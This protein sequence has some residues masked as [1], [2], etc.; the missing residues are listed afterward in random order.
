MFER[1]LTADFWLDF[2]RG[3]FSAVTTRGLL[4]LVILVGYAAAR[5]VLYRII[6]AAL[7][8]LL[9]RQARAA[10]G[11]ERA[12]RLRTL[13]GLAKSVV[14]YVL[15]F[16]L[17]IMLLDAVGANVAGLLTTAG[18]GGLAVGF[19]AQ[20]LVKDVISGFFLIVED[21]FVVG[22]YVTIGAATGVVEE[23]G[24]R[25]TRIRD[26]QGRLWV[27]ANGDISTVTNHSR[28]PVQA[29]VDVGIAPSA[30]VERARLLIDEAARDLHAGEPGA[31][32]AA[33]RVTGIAGWDAARV[34]LRVAVSA[35][36]PH[37]AEEQIRV[38][39]AIH[40]RLSAEGIP[41]A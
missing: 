36:P 38:R 32:T 23:L 25:I 17:V 5:A 22:D 35:V 2:Y 3:V 13:Q 41:L 15:L 16:V 40:Q 30:D 4:I 6:D 27:L 21:Q 29:F 28:A 12:S 18:V 19:G 20:K 34:T 26:D 39:S 9:A 11:E 10:T 14:G 8:R 1:A 33:P 37:L 7:A 31:L 24:M